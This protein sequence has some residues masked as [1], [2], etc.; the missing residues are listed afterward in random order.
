MFIEIKTDVG[1]YLL[2][3]NNIV[4][5]KKDHESSAIKMVT[6]D[7]YRTNNTYPEIQKLL[8]EML[9]KIAQ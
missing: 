5:I 8:K 3:V 2:N 9:L 7:T 1:T 4:S 6:G